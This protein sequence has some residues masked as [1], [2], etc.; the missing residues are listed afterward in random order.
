MKYFTFLSAQTT[1]KHSSLAS[2]YLDSAEVV[3]LD[4]H[5]TRTQPPMQHTGV[6]STQSHFFLSRQNPNPF[7]DQSVTIQITNP[8][9]NVFTPCFTV[10]TIYVLLL[11]KVSLSSCIH[12]NLLFGLSRCFIGSIISVFEKAQP[13]CLTS[14]NHDLIPKCPLD[15]GTPEL[16]S[17][18]PYL[19]PQQFCL[20]QTQQI[21]LVSYKTQIFLGSLR[22][23][24]SWL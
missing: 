19:A 11:S 6:S 1:P 21:L 9:L 14:Q 13:T 24:I 4:E 15:K 3:Y 12:A 22:Y 2:E 5:M 8:V 16:I 20:I 17:E 18:S 10:F 7:F 23:C